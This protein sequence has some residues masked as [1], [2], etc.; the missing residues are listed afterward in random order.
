MNDLRIISADSMEGR[1]TGTPGNEKARA[2][3]LSRLKEMRIS[4]L[5]NSFVQTFHFETKR[6]NATGS[7][8]LCLIK[9]ET[10]DYFVVS[11]HYD[12]LGVKNG[13]IYNGADDNASGTCALLAIAEFY[14]NNPP[15][16]N[17]ILAFFDA[18]EEGLQGAKAFVKEN[19]LPIS[20]N[21]NLDM[22]S[23]ND[24]N[25]I[26]AAGITQNP[27]LKPYIENAARE[28]NGVKILYGHDLPGSGG[29]DWSNSS[30]HGPFKEA[31]IPFVY[32]GVEDH[33]DYHK[34]SDDANKVDQGF[35][36]SVV[37][38]LIRV[39]HQLDQGLD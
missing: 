23:R 8:I 13:E 3:L 32:F 12:H 17:L 4:P 31:G 24:E 1:E 29:N 16:H 2:Y 30:D 39:L 20:L 37:N 27:T 11:A 36:T 22:V 38:L 9:G 18:E 28:I 19:T 6:N 15:H 10:D 5:G 21:L 14:R 25:E 33:P 26:Y 7:N 34:P 35:Y